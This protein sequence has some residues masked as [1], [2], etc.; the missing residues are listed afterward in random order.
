MIEDIFKKIKEMPDMC[1]ALKTLMKPEMEEER[2]EARQ[3]EAQTNI[4]NLMRSM[5]L[6]LEQAMVALCIPEEERHLYHQ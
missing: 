3:E 2:R 6:S 4:R 1:E 5:K